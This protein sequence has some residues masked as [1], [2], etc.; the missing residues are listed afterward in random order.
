MCISGSKTNSLLSL[1]PTDIDNQVVTGPACSCRL[2]P[3]R[4]TPPSLSIASNRGLGLTPSNQQKSGT[5][6]LSVIYSRLLYEGLS[7]WGI[8]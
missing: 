6:L 5:S 7:V 2:G 4:D 3:W 1:S 8:S